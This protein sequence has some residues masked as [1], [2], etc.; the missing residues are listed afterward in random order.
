MSREGP[1]WE[2]SGEREDHI[3]KLT[4]RTATAM[5]GALTA[6]GSVGIA[7][8]AHADG[9]MALTY[10]TNWIWRHL[11]AREVSRLRDMGY[12]EEQIRMAANLAMRTG[13]DMDYI[14]RISREANRPITE[15]AAIWRIDAA[16]LNNEI[17]GFGL[18]PALPTSPATPTDKVKAAPPKPTNN[19]TTSP[20]GP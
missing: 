11:D 10:R 18:E 2:A 5:L 3:M 6:L 7:V 15:Q 17:P 9:D 20:A 12:N 19:P 4:I 14:L 1:E 16:D 13:L 8:P